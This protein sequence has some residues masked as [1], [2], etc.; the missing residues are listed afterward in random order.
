MS[1]GSFPAFGHLS[2]SKLLQPWRRTSNEEMTCSSPNEVTTFQPSRGMKIK[3]RVKRR[4]KDCQLEWKDGIL[5]NFCKTHPR[6]KQMLKQQY[7][8][9][10][11]IMTYAM[12][13]RVRPW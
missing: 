2:S 4:C 9:N 3:G 5:Y 12:Q 8:P 13:S 11:R 7:W 6:H 10:L 1:M